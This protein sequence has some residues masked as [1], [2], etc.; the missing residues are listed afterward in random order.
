MN[1]NHSDLS[2]AKSRV[3]PQSILGFGASQGEM[4]ARKEFLSLIPVAK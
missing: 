1:G 2:H 4:W 3:S